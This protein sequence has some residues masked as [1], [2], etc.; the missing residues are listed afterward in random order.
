MQNEMGTALRRKRPGYGGDIA[1]KR[2]AEG[3]RRF[4]LVR[5]R[6]GGVNLGAQRSCYRDGKVAEATDT[7]DHDPLSRL[8]ATVLQTG[9]RCQAG[10]AE[11]RRVHERQVV[12]EWDGAICGEAHVLGV[13]ARDSQSGQARETQHTGFVFARP[14]IGAIPAAEQRVDGNPVADRDPSH[15]GPNLR[16]NADWFVARHERHRRPTD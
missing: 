15:T 3:A 9:V 12:R 1:R 5:T 6:R 2:G 11:R 4:C 8:Q 10:A 13:S 7:D 16:N 14:T